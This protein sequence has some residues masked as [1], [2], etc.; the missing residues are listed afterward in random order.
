MGYG[1][2]GADELRA[3][4]GNAE[5]VPI[6]ITEVG[7]VVVFMVLGTKSGPALVSTPVLESDLVRPAHAVPVLCKKGDHL[8]ASRVVGTSV[9][10]TTDHEERSGTICTMPT[11]PWFSG[12][13]PPLLETQ[14]SH[15]RLVEGKSALEVCHADEDM[16]EHG[17]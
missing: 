14:G 8:A 10:W 12:I 13:T 4:A 1:N 7:T 16:R 6:G 17:F 2:S 5:L 9:I 15:Q 11:G 3:M